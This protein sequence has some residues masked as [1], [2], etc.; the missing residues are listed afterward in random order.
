VG[1]LSVLLAH[2]ESQRP[3]SINSAPGEIQL[4]TFLRAIWG[5]EILSEIEHLGRNGSFFWT[6]CVPTLPDRSGGRNDVHHRFHRNPAHLAR[7]LVD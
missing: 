5:E 4:V 7:K 3:R 6:K 2:I 1:N